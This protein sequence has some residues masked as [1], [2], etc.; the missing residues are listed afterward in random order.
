MLGSILGS[1][2]LGKLL[3]MGVA[4]VGCCLDRLVQLLLRIPIP[5]FL[6]LPQPQ[7]KDLLGA[8]NLNPKFKV[9]VGA[10]SATSIL[11]TYSP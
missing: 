9:D 10:M 11:S 6:R 7:T 4:T 8:L 5:L 2:Y 3:Y 1:P